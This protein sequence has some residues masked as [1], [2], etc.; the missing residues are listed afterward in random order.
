M[1]LVNKNSNYMKKIIFFIFIM[2]LT[3]LFSQ[4]TNNIEIN[5]TNLKSAKGTIRVSLFTKS[6]EDAFPSDK[7][8]AYKI[9]KFKIDSKTQTFVLENLP[10]HEYAFSI[11]HDEDGNNKLNK[12]WI[13]MPKEG[14]GA[15]NNA[16]GNFGPPSYKQ[17][18]F[19]LTD[20]PNSHKIE[21]YYP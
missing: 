17:A 10:Y 1:Y 7:D 20:K 8:K 4:N 9:Y 18:K 15:S 16:R 14:L 21:L 6:N 3:I 11:H 19:K 5:I 2:P 12:N 13:G